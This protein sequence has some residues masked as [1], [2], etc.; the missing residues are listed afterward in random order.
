MAKTYNEADLVLAVQ[1]IQNNPKLSKRRAAKIYKVP[2][3]T[4]RARLSGRLSRRDTQPNSRIMTSL[5]EEVIVK[6]I[7][8]LDARAFPPR[9]ADV[10]AM[11]N[12]LCVTRNAPRLERAGPRDLSHADQ[13]LKLAGI[14]HMTIRGPNAKIQ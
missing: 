4:L 12:S 10:E 6:H 3:S 1:A 11:A 14:A 2:E 8:D 7:L 5:E 13:S 9:I